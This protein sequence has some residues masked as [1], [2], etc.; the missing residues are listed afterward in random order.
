MNQ[1]YREKSNI[2]LKIERAA[3]VELLEKAVLRQDWK[4]VYIHQAAI[5][6]IKKEI[7]ARRPIG[8]SV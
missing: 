5:N 7:I 3:L 6:Q 4:T 1:N 8:S 2:H